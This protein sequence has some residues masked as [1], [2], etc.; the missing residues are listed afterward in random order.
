MKIL[1]TGALGFIGGAL[2]DHFCEAGHEV[3][4]VDRKPK[5]A[6]LH[7]EAN[8]FQVELSNHSGVNELAMACEKVD[9]VFHFAGQSSAEA[10]MTDPIEDLRSNYLS[11]VNLVKCFG[12]APLY[13]F[14]SSMAVY[15]DT[16][17]V[18]TER[19]LPRP[20]SNYGLHKRM[21]EKFLLGSASINR[22]AILRMF[23][24]Y[25]PGQNLNRLDQGMLSIY[26]GMAL[27]NRRLEV[28]GPTDRTRDFVWV[29]DLIHILEDMLKVGVKGKVI[30]N[31]ST[32]RVVTVDQAIRSLSNALGAELVSSQLR[33]TRGDVKGFSGSTDLREA[34]FGTWTM[35]TL[36]EG[37]ARWV[38]ALET[39]SP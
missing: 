33:R 34:N 15:G 26:L 20:V 21:S 38:Q 5:R 7:P 18:A 8:F 10:S 12:S 27:K 11:T 4:A 19:D 30:L 9:A 13:F 23:N 16:Q 39:Q 6:D 29:F 17:G 32:G 25:G 24:V 2:V 1:V 37:L 14:A 28:K 35:V 3:F 31:V 36:D 22:V